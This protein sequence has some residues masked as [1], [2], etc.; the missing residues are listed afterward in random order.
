MQTRSLPI[1]NGV[2]LDINDTSAKDGVS[3][4][5]V[6]AYTDRSGAIRT[7]PGCTEYADTGAGDVPVWSYYS[8]DLEVLVIVAGGFSRRLSRMGRSSRYPAR[9]F[10]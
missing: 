7:V 4:S 6:N 5:F 10:L 8:T 3:I 2:T 1:G 9:P